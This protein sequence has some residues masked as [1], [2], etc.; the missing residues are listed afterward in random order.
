MF[1]C[2]ESARAFS[3]GIGTWQQNSRVIHATSETPGGSYKRKDVTW[4]VFSHE[5]EVVPAPG[6]KYVMYFTAALRSEHGLC[7]CC[8]PGHGPCDGSTG[9]GDCGRQEGTLTGTGGSGSYMSW[10]DDPNGNWSAPQLMF[11]NYHGGDTNFAP[12]ILPNGSIVAMWRHWGGGNGGSRQFL[13][14]AADWRDPSSYVQH[15]TELFPDLGAAG[16]EDQFVY[17]D[18]DENFHAVFHHSECAFAHDCTGVRTRRPSRSHAVALCVASQCT[19]QA[20]R[21][22]GGWTPP[23]VMPSPKTGGAGPT[24]ELR[25]ATPLADTTRQRGRGRRYAS[26]TAQPQ[27]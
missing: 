21:R 16:T 13:A 6:G 12:L 24:L 15:H 2:T 14:T 8:R 20:R 4:E 17:Q 27:R 1:T 25:G 5:P 11:Q 23:E 3:G 26:L 7:N 22:N 10:T 18:E 9:T 19:A